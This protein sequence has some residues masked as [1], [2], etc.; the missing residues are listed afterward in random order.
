M[1]SMHS[2]PTTTLP[3]EDLIGLFASEF[4]ELVDFDSF[5]FENGQQPLHVFIGMP[6]LH[7]CRYRLVCEKLEFGLITLTRS[8]PF[9]N[10]EIN[11]IEGALSGLAI[12]LGNAMNFQAALSLESLNSLK[13][14][15]RRAFVG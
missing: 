8:R 6:K 10:H 14:V 11:M 3:M 5:E 7:K 15:Q 12:H 4:R 9:L 2:D 1:T 13:G